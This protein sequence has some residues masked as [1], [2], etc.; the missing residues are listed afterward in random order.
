[1]CQNLI[2][3]NIL[4]SSYHFI[5]EGFGFVKFVNQLFKE[6]VAQP[7]FDLRPELCRVGRYVQKEVLHGKVKLFQVC[8]CC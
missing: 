4:L 6:D 8:G 7:Q 1:M 5:N 2:E 3:E